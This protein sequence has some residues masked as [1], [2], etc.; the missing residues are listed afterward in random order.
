LSSSSSLWLAH[1]I[2]FFDR[3]GRKKVQE[4]QIRFSSTKGVGR[5]VHTSMNKTG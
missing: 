3:G 2:S 4:V 1:Y 5:W